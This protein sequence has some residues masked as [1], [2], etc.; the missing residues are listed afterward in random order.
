MVT[1]KIIC[2]IGLSKVVKMMN[3]ILKFIETSF[4]ENGSLRKNIF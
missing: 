4:K 3:Q 1:T 2:T